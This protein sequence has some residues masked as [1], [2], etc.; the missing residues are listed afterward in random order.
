MADLFLLSGISPA[1]IGLFYPYQGG[2]SAARDRGCD[3]LIGAGFGNATFS[4]E[5]RRGYVEF[6]K[7]GRFRQLWRALA[8]RP[9][10][11]R[12]T[13]RRL[14]SLSLLRA[15]P[16][17]AWRMVSRWRGAEPIDHHRTAGALNPL[18]PGRAALEQAAH[19][20]DPSLNRPFFRSRAEEVSAMA[21]QI[22]ADGFDL[23]QGLEQKYRIAFRDV[24]RYRP[25][26][27]FCWGLPTDQLMRDGESR[28][29][30]RRMGRGRIP[31]AI[32]TDPRYGL[33]HGDWHQRIGRRREA[34]LAE[35]RQLRENAQASRLIDIPR[36]IDLLENFPETSSDDPAIAYQYQIALPNGIAIARLIRYV[37]GANA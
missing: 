30:A 17:P 20:A 26:V 35:L 31:E 6:L 21:Q 27:E 10:D 12:A 19:Q 37:S 5:G 16:L 9:G 25:F 36:L 3:L 11:D 14:V 33:Q 18:W 29:L 23:M 8:A 13:W 22:D 28:Y 1:S 34:L 32:R 4:A 24:T 15:L 2:F 7:Q